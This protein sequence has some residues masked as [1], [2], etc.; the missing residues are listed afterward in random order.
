LYTLIGG[1]RAEKF[2]N[3]WAIESVKTSLDAG[4]NKESNELDRKVP[5]HLNF[6]K[7]IHLCICRTDFLAIFRE[8]QNTR[9]LHPVKLFRSVFCASPTSE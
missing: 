3:H 8:N 1:Q 9:S 5:L 6:E 2:E 4:D 7:Y